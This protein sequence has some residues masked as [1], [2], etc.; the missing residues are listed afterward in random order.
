MTEQ[1]LLIQKMRAKIEK[2]E[3]TQCQWFDTCPMAVTKEA[4]PSLDQIKRMA[5]ELGYNLIPNNSWIK[6][7]PCTCG[8][9]RLEAWYGPEGPYWVC[10]DC[11]KRG[12]SA[13][14]ERKAAMAW[15][16]MI[17]KER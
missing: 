16:E 8:R 5:K 15:N 17:E 13:P 7:L 11:G 10:P 2:L 4:Q 1:D 9:K 12:P 6:K 14:T 3:S